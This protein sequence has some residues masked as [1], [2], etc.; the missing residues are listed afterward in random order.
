MNK[1]PVIF[2]LI[3]VLLGFYLLGRSLGIIWF[4]M[5]DLIWLLFP[6]G[7][8]VLG[9]W[10][11]IRK[12]RQEERLHSEAYFTSHA[13]TDTGQ[14]STAP[15]PPPHSDTGNTM[16][17]QPNLS[18]PGTSST[19]GTKT[20]EFPSK[21]ERGPVKYSKF[22]G[23]MYI[24]C[25]GVSLQNVEMSLGI[26]DLEVKLH[27]GKLSPGLNRMIIS[28]FIGDVRIFAPPDMAIFFHCS[29]F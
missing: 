17:D 1:K 12:K 19:A 6:F 15:P 9:I 29:N 25:I 14:T 4:S 10:L 18:T 5:G 28:G 3:L 8:I 7:L 2:G 11:I 26:G 16:G 21:E 23:D 22:L 13:T 20:T 27:G 24:N